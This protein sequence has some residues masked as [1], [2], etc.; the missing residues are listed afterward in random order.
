MQYETPEKSRNLT[1]PSCGDQ[2]CPL[3][4]FFEFVPDSPVQCFCAAPIRIGYRLKSP[5]FSY[6]HPYYNEFKVYLTTSLNLD[7]SQLSID[8]FFW[9]EGPRLRMYLKLFPV[10]DNRSH[11]FNTSEIQRIRGV[12]T[13]WRFPRTDFF[14]PY[15]LLNFTLLG[16]YYDGT[17]S[18]LISPI[19]CEFCIIDETMKNDNACSSI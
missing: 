7:V 14:G 3:D 16:P 1:E 2:S 13:S 4:N 11:T 15:E 6:F 5:S 10:Y 8:S 19:S 18:N 9:E 12:F 17:Y